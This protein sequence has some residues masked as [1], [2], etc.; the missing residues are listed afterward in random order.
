VADEWR[1]LDPD[2]FPFVHSIVDE[3][4]GHDDAEQFRAGLDLLLAGLRLQTKP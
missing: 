1:R 2:A 4:A 3:F